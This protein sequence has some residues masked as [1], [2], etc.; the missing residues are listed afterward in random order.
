MEAEV[1]FSGIPTTR[2]GAV[3]PW[4]ES[5]FGRPPD[6]VAN[7]REVMWR[8]RDGAWL[9]VVEDPDRA[10]HGLVTIA[11]CDLDAVLDELDGRGIDRPEVEIVADA[12]RKA[13]LADPDGNA[14]I[15]VQVDGGS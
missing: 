5:L 9:Y 12:G 15:L 11:V 8:V 3:Q 13:P 1:L 14:V 6:V 4:Y 10:G 7:D 2:L